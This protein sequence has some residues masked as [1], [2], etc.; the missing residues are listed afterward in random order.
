MVYT[1]NRQIY[2]YNYDDVLCGVLC[3]LFDEI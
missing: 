2:D 3:K 1:L